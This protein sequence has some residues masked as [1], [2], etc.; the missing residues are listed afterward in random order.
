MFFTKKININ[1]EIINNNFDT[2]DDIVLYAWT[3]E[4]ELAELF[5]D[6]RDMNK[7]V[8]KIVKMS[9]KKISDFSHKYP[10]EILVIEEVVFNRS[11]RSF[12]TCDLVLTLF[13]SELCTYEFDRIFN[14]LIEEICRISPDI[15]QQKY[16]KEL[17]RILY[18]TYHEIHGSDDYD[19]KLFVAELLYS[20]NMSFYGCLTGGVT[21]NTMNMFIYLFSNLLK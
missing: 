10:S 2:D 13:E 1:S 18:C 19:H 16:L 5:I 15:F 3:I 21:E 8:Y 17:D 6:S 14:C 11:N 4:S 9:G 12:D 7:F 20:Q